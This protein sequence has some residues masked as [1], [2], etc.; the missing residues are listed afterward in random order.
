MKRSYLRGNLGG[1][2]K[3]KV[4]VVSEKAKEG[5]MLSWYRGVN[6]TSKVKTYKSCQGIMVLFFVGRFS[7]N[8]KRKTRN[9]K[10]CRGVGVQAVPVLFLVPYFLRCLSL[11]KAP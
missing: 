6:K 11:S 7:K 8:E 3:K 1:N 4:I 10:R 9:E 2:G 5:V